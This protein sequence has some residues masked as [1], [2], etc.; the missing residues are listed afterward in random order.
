MSGEEERWVDDK[1]DISD[2]RSPTRLRLSFQP[3]QI[4]RLL[5]ELVQND[6]SL[7]WYE[8]K[9]NWQGMGYI[10]WKQTTGEF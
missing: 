8:L 7:Q 5:S 2:K 3:V 6:H 9:E 4:M 1:W 10:L